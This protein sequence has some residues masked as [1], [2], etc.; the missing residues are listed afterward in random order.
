M[1]QNIQHMRLINGEEIVADILT[2]T[3]YSVVV[4]NPMM[5]EERK[6]ENGSS[7]ILTKYIPFSK[8][9]VCELN[10]SHIITFNQLHPELIR[11]YYNSLKFN[12]KS[13]MKMVEEITRVN[14]LMEQIMN[15]QKEE[16]SLENGRIMKTTNT[17]H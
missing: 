17:K 15:Q 9:K 1:T 12:D 6:D 3:E 7:L 11:Y 10:K 4:D 8:N 16:L 2:E 5:V 13:E 14:H